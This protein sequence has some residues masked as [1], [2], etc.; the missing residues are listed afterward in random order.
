MCDQVQEGQ[1]QQCFSKS[2]F[3]EMLWQFRGESDHYMLRGKRRLVEIGLLWRSGIGVGLKGSVG[4]R[5][6]R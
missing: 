4:F 5:E 2:R 3:L 1:L 6:K